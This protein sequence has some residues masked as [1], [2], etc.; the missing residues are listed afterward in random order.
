MRVLSVGT[1][2]LRTDGV[3]DGRTGMTELIVSFRNF[4][5]AQ[6]K[7]NSYLTEKKRP[8]PLQKRFFPPFVYENIRSLL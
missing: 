2:L 6:K 1:E 5:N 7:I 8:F 4:T 3:T